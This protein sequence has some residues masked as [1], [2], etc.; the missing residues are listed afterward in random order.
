[1]LF[2]TIASTGNTSDFGDLTVAR[3]GGAGLS[4]S[5]KTLFCGGDTPA[6][7][8]STVDFVFTASTGNAVDFGDLIVPTQNPMG[9]SNKH[10]A[11]Q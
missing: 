5:T 9:C 8:S 11:L 1:M 7:G 6:P 4:D 3:A 10:G 2:I